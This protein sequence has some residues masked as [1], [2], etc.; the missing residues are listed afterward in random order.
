MVI[1]SP[2]GMLDS[3]RPR[4]KSEPP[5]AQSPV[6]ALINPIVGCGL[7]R[8]MPVTVEDAAAMGGA[9]RAVVEAL[10][11]AGV[12]KPVLQ[13]GLPDIFIEHRDPARLM[14]MHWLDA[15]GIQVSIEKRFPALADQARQALKIVA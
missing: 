2:P 1:S 8:R 4:S 10:H 15:A 14:A 3:R 9:V 12:L 7:R 5:F 11:H 6:D 13:L